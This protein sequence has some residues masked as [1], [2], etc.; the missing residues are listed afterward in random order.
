MK[1]LFIVI[2]LLSLV[3]SCGSKK[4]AEAAKEVKGTEPIVVTDEI[5]TLEALEGEY[6][7]L[8]ADTENC[9]A[10]ITIIKRCEGV[11][12]RNS[13]FRHESYCNVNRGE[14]KTG[15]NRSS[16]TVTLEA[17]KLKTVSLIFDERSTPP[18]K[19]K[20]TFES[21]LSFDENGD[22]LKVADLSAGKTICLYKK[23]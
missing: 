4:T 17:K 14:I 23:R 18:G 15:D 22:L 2:S 6:D 12:V 21:S 16:T 19:V 5:L 9:G 7:L 1:K 3:S 20:Q 10:A 11:Q 13:N 8:R